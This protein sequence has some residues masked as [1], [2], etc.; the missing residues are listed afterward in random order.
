MFYMIE[1]KHV[2]RDNLESINSLKITQL[3]LCK[4]IRIS[5]LTKQHVSVVRNSEICNLIIFTSGSSTSNLSSNEFIEIVYSYLFRLKY[6][7]HS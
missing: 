2:L 4:S 7:G 6:I 3:F 5:L 1:F